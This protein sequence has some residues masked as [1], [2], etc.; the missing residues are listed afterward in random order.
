MPQAKSHEFVFNNIPAD[1]YPLVI[2]ITGFINARMVLDESVLQKVKMVLVEMMTNAIKHS[3]DT[4]SLIKI[5]LSEAQIVISKSDT[6]NTMAIDIYGLK[7]D[8]PLP[9][10]HHLNT[11]LNIY[12]QNESRLM[13]ILIGNC[14][15]QFYIDKEENLNDSSFDIKNIHEHFGLMIITRACKSFEYFFDIGNCTNNFIATVSI[16]NII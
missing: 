4:E 2:K 6:G 7:W 1:L 8:W 16:N 9:G 12:Q 14:R 15:L 13:A 5:D 3:G 11:R 10:I